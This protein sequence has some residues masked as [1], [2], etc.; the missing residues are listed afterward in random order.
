MTKARDL[1]NIVAIGSGD[2]EIP[3]DLSVVGTTTLSAD[4][5][6]ALQAATKSYVDTI[7]AAGLHYHD[8]VRVESPVNL[9][10]TY[11]NGTAG[12]GATLTNAGTQEAITIDGV[13][14]SLNDRVLLYVQTD[15]TQNGIY[16]VTTVGD[17]STNWVLTR[18]IDADSYSPSD[19]DS[20]GQ[21]DAFF[22]LEGATGAG[23]L[24]VMN[25]EGA[26]TFGTTNI[27]FAQVAATGIYTAGTNL[28]IDG[29]AFS[30][31]ASPTF[32]NIT[33][34]GTVDGRDIAQ[35]IP[36]SLG[37]AGQVLT[38]NT[39]ATAAEWVDV[40]GGTSNGFVYFMKG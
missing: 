38:V 40:S 22:V 21:G 35:N 36:A 23:E 16:T 18:A 5:V 13:A 11:N 1:A 2:I 37:T 28:Q 20:L 9:N 19:P 10:A 24:Y 30:T 39:G 14:L 32:T 33:V 15:A 12:V 17:G 27:T 25:T 3:G 29:T 4:P 8:P 7:A 34:S 31:V 6:S 26:I